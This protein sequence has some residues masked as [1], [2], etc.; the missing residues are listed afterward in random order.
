MLVYVDDIIIASNSIFSI[1][2]LES[3]LNAKFKI[4][5]FGD[6]KFFLGMKVVRPEKRNTFAS[7]SMP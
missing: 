7:A 3:D 2:Q 5:D 4:K 1:Y 6:L